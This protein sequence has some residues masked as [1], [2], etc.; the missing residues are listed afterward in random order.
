MII[1]D[2][3]SFR[4]A[5]VPSLEANKQR[6]SYH[7]NWV[8]ISYPVEDA[9]GAPHYTQREAFIDLDDKMQ[10]QWAEKLVD[11]FRKQEHFSCVCIESNVEDHSTKGEFVAGNLGN[12]PEFSALL[13]ELAG[14]PGFS[15][16]S[17]NSDIL[18]RPTG[19]LTVGCRPYDCSGPSAEEEISLEDC[20][21]AG[22]SASLAHAARNVME[23]IGKGPGIVEITYRGDNPDEKPLAMRRDMPI[24]YLEEGPMAEIL[25]DAAVHVINTLLMRL[26]KV[27]PVF[28]S[29][30]GEPVKQVA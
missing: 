26:G 1:R 28:T 24:E 19:S 18:L 5:A 4:L 17:V 7:L 25:Y 14:F 9:G 3:S 23:E 30:N 27:G 22:L 29:T 11:L 10:K 6:D 13:A 15:F 21:K 20:S 12:M 2:I 16:L 8:A